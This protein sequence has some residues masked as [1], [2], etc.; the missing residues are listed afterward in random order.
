MGDTLYTHVF[1]LVKQRFSYIR[2]FSP[3]LIKHLQL[4]SEGNGNSTLLN[5]VDILRKMNDENKRKLSNDV[6]LDFIPKKIRPLVEVNGMV[7]KAAWKCA[8]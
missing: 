2:Q 3:A 5:A 4:I 6:P 8:L 7:N 1:N